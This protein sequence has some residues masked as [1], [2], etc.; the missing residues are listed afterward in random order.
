[1]SPTSGKILTLK[2]YKKFTYNF[3][4]GILCEIETIHMWQW[5]IIS[6]V[7]FYRWNLR[8]TVLSFHM[9]NYI[10]CVKVNFIKEI[11]YVELRHHLRKVIF[12]SEIK[13]RTDG[14]SERSVFLKTPF[15][16]IPACIFYYEE[17][18]V[19]QWSSG[20]RPIF[21]CSIIITKCYLCYHKLN[22][23]FHAV[24]ISSSKRAMST[25]C[26]NTWGKQVGNVYFC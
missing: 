19:L 5:S 25:K 13:F 7:K 8:F 3:T 23:K 21:G 12:I 16:Q 15:L 4:C 11:S 18:W 1:M 14:A 24:R 22:S 20:K 17:F 26:H 2:H 9:W 6:H 10:L